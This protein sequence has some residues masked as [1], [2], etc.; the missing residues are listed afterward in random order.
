M[1]LLWKLKQKLRNLQNKLRK[2]RLPS[3]CSYLWHKHTHTQNAQNFAIQLQQ[4][5]ERELPDVPAGFRRVRSLWYHF[6]ASNEWWKRQRSSKNVSF[7]FWLCRPHNKLWLSFK[8]ISSAFWRIC[9]I[10]KN[11]RM[12]YGATKWFNIGT[13]CI[14]IVYCHFLLFTVYAEYIMRNAG[15]EEIIFEITVKLFGATV[16][17]DMFMIYFDGR[18]KV[19]LRNPLLKMKKVKKPICCSILTRTK[20]MSEIQ[21]S[22][23]TFSDKCILFKSFLECTLLHQMLFNQIP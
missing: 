19:D 23:G 2:F 3:N 22:D 21:R 11:N 13:K 20:I 9:M 1:A 12:E 7:C 16:T 18:S 15:I 17:S 6:T 4:L 14:S 5:M 8:N 10:T